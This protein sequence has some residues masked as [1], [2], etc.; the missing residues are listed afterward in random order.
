MPKRFQPFHAPKLAG[1]PAFFRAARHE[2][3]HETLRH[4]RFP[5]SRLP[6]AALRLYVVPYERVPEEMKTEGYPP[7]TRGFSPVRGGLDHAVPHD[8]TFSK[9]RHGRS[10][11]SEL[12]RDLFEEIVGRCLA[13]GLVEGESFSVDGSLIE[14][15]AGRASRVRR[16][17]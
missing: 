13:A 10:R 6:R 16:A 3:R 1:L 8:S 7:T 2:T 17:S 11:E 14:A 9:N 12:F 15:D 4:C 5:S